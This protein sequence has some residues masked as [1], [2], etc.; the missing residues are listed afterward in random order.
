M[1]GA[2]T[3]VASSSTALLTVFSLMRG[4]SNDPPSA[5]PVQKVNYDGSLL[6]TW[7]SESYQDGEPLDSECTWYNGTHRLDASACTLFTI[8]RSPTSIFQTATERAARCAFKA[9]TECVLS[10]EIGLSVPTAFVV[11][12]TTESGMVAII[13]PKIV[14]QEDEKYVRV[15]VPPDS[16]FE[17]SVT[18][19]NHSI[20]VEYMDGFK[21]MKK[22]QLTGSKAFCVQLLRRAYDSTCWANLDS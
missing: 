19:M 16:I 13:A 14:T 18:T 6:R 5:I 4:S 10:T 20:V 21:H 11:D 17:V 1:P 15:S 8:S 7:I 2:Q 22:M 9:E 3:I 12:Q